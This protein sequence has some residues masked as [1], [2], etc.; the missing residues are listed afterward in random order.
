MK[1][2][3]VASVFLNCFC[4]QHCDVF[5]SLILTPKSFFVVIS[6]RTCVADSLILSVC[7]LDRLSKL[8][9]LIGRKASILKFNKLLFHQSIEVMFY[10]LFYRNVLGR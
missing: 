10:D 4:W 5:A 3:S 1:H 2:G 8:K 9:L 7:L 6:W